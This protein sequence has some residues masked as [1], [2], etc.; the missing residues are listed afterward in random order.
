M[1]G[2][3]HRPQD[4]QTRKGTKTG[5]SPKK[6]QTLSY[7]KKSKLFNIFHP[8]PHSPKPGQLNVIPTEARA[9]VAQVG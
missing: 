6:E 4:T 7:N 3:G 8:L 5:H 9:S 2:E 1:G